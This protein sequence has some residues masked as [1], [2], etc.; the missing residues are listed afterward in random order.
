M[1]TKEQELKNRL[2]AVLR[3]LKDNGGKEPEAIW[4][5]GSLAVSLTDKAKK[6]SWPELKNSLTAEAYTKLLADFETQ[7]NLL[8]Q[9]GEP[10]KAYAIQAL[11][12]SLVLR[13]HRGDFQ[14]REGEALL[15]ALIEGAVK[16]YRKTQRVN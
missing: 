14:L 10:H 4:R 2:G 16:L 7:G 3:D 13:T 11:G 12:I 15:D 6:P 9:R 1:A 5:I 8:V